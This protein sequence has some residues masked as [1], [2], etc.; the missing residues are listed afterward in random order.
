MNGTIIKALSGFYYVYHDHSIYACKARGKFRK[1]NIKPLVGDEVVFQI[2]NGTEG[3]ILEIKERKNSLIRPQ[4][5]NIDQ[6][7]I[8]VSAHEPDFQRMLCNK[9]L[10]MVENLKI[11]PIIVI[12]KMDLVE[13]NDEVYLDDS[14]LRLGDRIDMPFWRK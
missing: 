3:Y 12:T 9:F 5:A 7:F 11:H 13:E 1:M 6:A 10:M 14:A 2:E 8:I 4:I